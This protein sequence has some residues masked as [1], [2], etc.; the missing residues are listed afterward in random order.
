MMRVSNLGCQADSDTVPVRRRSP[1]AHLNGQGIKAV[2]GQARSHERVQGWVR[3]R[4]RERFS[5]SP[6]VRRYYAATT[7]DPA[8]DPTSLD[9]VFE[10]YRLG[11]P[12][13]TWLASRTDR[14][15]HHQA[16]APGAVSNCA[17]PE[18]TPQF[19]EQ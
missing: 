4:T 2:G 9:Q 11:I 13:T 10:L 16:P 17:P 6:Q 19:T 5:V 15:I 1:A 18:L 7:Y 14:H 12:R 8:A 3:V